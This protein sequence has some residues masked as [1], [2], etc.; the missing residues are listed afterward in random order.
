M[1]TEG[2]NSQEE[3]GDE[4]DENGCEKDRNHGGRVETS[5]KKISF[6]WIPLTLMGDALNVNIDSKD[7]HFPVWLL[8]AL[9]VSF[10]YGVLMLEA[11]RIMVE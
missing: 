10:Y 11:S 6:Y 8:L 4:D 2:G 9:G 5:N 7:H 3:D 1:C